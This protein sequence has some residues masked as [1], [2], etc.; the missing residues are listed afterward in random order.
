[1]SFNDRNIPREQAANLMGFVPATSILLRRVRRI[2]EPKACHAPLQAGHPVT[3]GF[4]H[5]ATAA[6]VVTGSPGQAGQ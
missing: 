6:P 3:T 4:N 1:M 5:L 2:S